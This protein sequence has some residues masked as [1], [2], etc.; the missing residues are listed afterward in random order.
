M[1]LIT[2]LL[3]SLSICTA[4]IDKTTEYIYTGMIIA[5]I[6]SMIIKKTTKKPGLSLLIGAISAVG[7]GF[8]RVGALPSMLRHEKVN[9]IGIFQHGFGGLTGTMIIGCSWNF[10]NSRNR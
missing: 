2:L 5:P 9:G 8:I 6:S 3:L 10:K 7:F 1:K 4:Q